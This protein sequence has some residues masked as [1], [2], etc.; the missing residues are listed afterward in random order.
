[1]LF[2]SDKFALRGVNITIVQHV[3]ILWIC[4]R[5]S[6]SYQ[7]RLALLSLYYPPIVQAVP[8]HNPRP[9]LRIRSR[10]SPVDQVALNMCGT[11]DPRAPAILTS[12][13][14]MYC[15]KPPRTGHVS[16]LGSKIFDDQEPYL[17]WVSK[18]ARSSGFSQ[19]NRL[20]ERP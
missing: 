9:T 13:S 19:F 10:F 7:D 6:L 5:V 16:V 3:L 4:Q 12:R 15:K 1:M 20:L 2:V 17:L 8:R 14:S 18:E 11:R